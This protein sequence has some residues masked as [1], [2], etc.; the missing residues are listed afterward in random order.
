MYANW[1]LGMNGSI[2]GGFGGESRHR[3]RPVNKDIH[4]SYVYPCVSPLL[5]P[6]S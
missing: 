5:S 4:R 6:L 2:I 1:K 3:Q